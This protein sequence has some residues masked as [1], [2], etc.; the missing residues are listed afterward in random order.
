MRAAGTV[1]LAVPA[2][3]SPRICTRGRGIRCAGWSLGYL[4]AAPLAARPWLLALTTTRAT[5]IVREVKREER[6]LAAA[7]GREYDHYLAQRPDLA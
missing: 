1:A 2:R 5:W 6:S 3:W 7:F 4:A